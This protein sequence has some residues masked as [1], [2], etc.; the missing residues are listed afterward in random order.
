MFSP[1][2]RPIVL[3][4]LNDWEAIRILREATQIST[5]WG[6]IIDV[7]STIYSFGSPKR[8]YLVVYQTLFEPLFSIIERGRL[9]FKFSHVVVRLKKVLSLVN[10]VRWLA[11]WEIWTVSFLISKK[12]FLEPEFLAGFVRVGQ[13]TLIL[14]LMDC[15]DLVANCRH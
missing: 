6:H 13:F 1:I 10:F 14:E 2:T 5:T 9:K 11:L 8:I 7:L 3:D 4:L 12:Y 15:S